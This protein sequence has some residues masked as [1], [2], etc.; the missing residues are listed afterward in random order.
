MPEKETPLQIVQKLL[1]N[2]AFSRWM[3]LE[4]VEAK[5]G[6]CSCAC[7]INNQMLNGYRIAHGGILF[8]L[9]DTAL[10]FAAA[11]YGEESIAIEHSIS[12]IK[13]TEPGQTVTA[14]AICE[15]M[16]RKT[17]VVKIEIR[18]SELALVALSKGTV[19]KTGKPI[20]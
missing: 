18:N 20:T 8:S 15:H 3:G 10:A 16:G 9:A 7:I 13:K 19:Y 6:L 11:T 14:T 17:A 2:D 5:P 4:I 1:N 12:F